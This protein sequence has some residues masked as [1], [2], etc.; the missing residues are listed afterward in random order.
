V[1]DTQGAAAGDGGDELIGR[2]VGAAVDEAG[3][4]ERLTLIERLFAL[5]PPDRQER[6]LREVLLTRAGEPA[7]GGRPRR[8]PGRRRGAGVLASA[9]GGM[10][11]R[12]IGPWRTC[13][14]MMADLDQAPSVDEIDAGLPAEVFAALGDETRLKIIRLLQD[15][16]LRFEDIARALDMPRS[17]LSHHLRVLRDAG[18]VEM[19]RRGRASYYSLPQP[20]ATR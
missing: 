9:P 4:D 7:A 18:L 10:P 8:R 2:L 17:T 6:L 5:L 13:C 15:A 1:T 11:V 19:D 12:D 14:R 20:D 16:E 3:P